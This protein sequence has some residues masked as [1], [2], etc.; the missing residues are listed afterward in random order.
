MDYGPARDRTWTATE[1]RVLSPLRFPFRHRAKDFKPEPGVE[2]GIPSGA[3]FLG[4]D[5]LSLPHLGFGP[6]GRCP[7][8]V[9]R[10]RSATP[11]FFVYISK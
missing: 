8:S 9:P 7:L 3:H 1:A 5:P 4:E 11:A 6:K 2:P 10:S